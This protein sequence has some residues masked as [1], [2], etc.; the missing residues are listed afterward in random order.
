MICSRS[1]VTA[2]V[3]LVAAFACTGL[4]GE[5]AHSRRVREVFTALYQDLGLA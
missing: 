5:A 2:E 4:C 3:G 1:A